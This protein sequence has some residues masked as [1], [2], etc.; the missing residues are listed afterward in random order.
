MIVPKIQTA[1][2]NVFWSIGATV[3]IIFDPD[4]SLRRCKNRP[5]SESVMRASNHV[6]LSPTATSK[7]C[8]T[9]ASVPAPKCRWS[10]PNQLPSSTIASASGCS[11]LPSS[12][13]SRSDRVR[14][15]KPFNPPNT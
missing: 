5:T 6:T 13:S 7:T 4:R 2:R 9:N 8:P 14:E 11:V 12:T 3:P 1:D 10:Y 15:A